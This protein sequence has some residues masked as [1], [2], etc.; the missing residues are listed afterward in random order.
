[1]SRRSWPAVRSLRMPCV[2]KPARP[3]R[4][5][6]SAADAFAAVPRLPVGDRGTLHQYATSSPAGAILARKPNRVR[7]RARGH[8]ARGRARTSRPRGDRRARRAAA[9][10]IA[11]AARSRRRDWAPAPASCDEAAGHVRP[12]A[13]LFL[14]AARHRSRHVPSV[15]LTRLDRAVVILGSASLAFLSSFIRSRRTP[16]TATRA[17]SASC[18]Q[19]CRSLLRSSARRQ[20]QAFTCPAD[21]RQGRGRISGS[22]LDRAPPTCPGAT[23]TCANPRL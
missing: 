11:R 16:R 14:S 1:M 4:S 5:P 22:L 6:I 10:P 7:E 3:A 20:R 15:L 8:D 12:G 21:W 9:R 2:D 18:R 23:T 13:A 17:F 19:T